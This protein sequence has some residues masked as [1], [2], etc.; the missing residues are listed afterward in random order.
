MLVVMDNEVPATTEMFD[1]TYS[2]VLRCECG[3]DK[4]FFTFYKK[5]C[6]P[7]HPFHHP[8][9]PI[10][11]AEGWKNTYCFLFYLILKQRAK[12]FKRL[13]DAIFTLQDL[14]FAIL[15]EFVYQCQGFNKF[16][17]STFTN[18]AKYAL[19]NTNTGKLDLNHLTGAIKVLSK[20]H[21]D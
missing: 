16:C 14:T 2:S 18:A 12:T 6:P 13:N 7:L 17:T 5:A 20:N 9:C 8:T 3:R 4:P 15:H 21:D 19:T 11:R 1:S 10:Y